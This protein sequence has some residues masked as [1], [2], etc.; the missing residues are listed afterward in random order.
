MKTLL[1]HSTYTEQMSY[2][3]DWIDA[4]KSHSDFSTLCINVFN[5]SKDLISD[6]K[7]KIE[8]YELIVLHHSMNGDTLKYLNPFVKALKNRRGKLVSF[9][10]NE[11][12]LPTIGMAP[13]I[14]NLQEIEA[15]FIATQ[16]LEEAGQWL[17]E[18]C[19]KA[20]VISLPHALNPEAFFSKHAFKDRKID[21]GTRSARYGVY[22][23]DNDRNSIIQYFYHNAHSLNLN[24]DLGLDSNSQKR[25]NRQEW[26]DFL[27]SC[28]ATL[29]TE[30]GSFYLEKDDI[31]VN[32]I[33]D[34]LKKRSVKIVLPH[35]TFARKA[36]R[37]IVPSFVRKI[38]VFLLKDRLVEIDNIDQECDFDELYEKFFRL[39]A[40]SPVYTKAISSRHFDAIGTKTL[41]VMYPGRYNDILI[42]GE[43][44]FE[45]KLDHSNVEDL[46]ELLLDL[47]IVK[48]IT[49][50]AYNHVITH[51]T[52]KNRLDALLKVL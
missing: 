35:E 31:I 30:A 48:N 43:H 26:S 19:N 9:V 29:S 34:F 11:V 42:P 22:V 8:N 18:D 10:G 45:L 12:N 49:E 1:L 6:V 47:R 17:Y 39:A 52:H 25:F 51:H 32:K 46:K 14:K 15:D 4:F 20:K 44:Y 2:F 40:K 7:S 28:K 23:G 36:Y 3:D 50:A 37:K 16:L 21:I 38:I 41:H 24:L 5:A 33:Q 13:K 27:S